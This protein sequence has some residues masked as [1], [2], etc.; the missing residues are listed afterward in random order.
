MEVHNEYILPVIMYGSETW[1]ISKTQLQKMI[2]TQC[3]MEQIMM[4]LTLCNRK[5]QAGSAQ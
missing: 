5:V 3:K 2:T 4:G 1:S